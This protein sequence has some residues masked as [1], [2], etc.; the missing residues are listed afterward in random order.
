M[1]ADA[2][3]W[4]CT[5]AGL[6]FIVRIVSRAKAPRHVK[7][8]GYTTIDRR[9]ARSTRCQRLLMAEHIGREASRRIRDQGQGQHTK[10]RMTRRNGLGHR[11]HTHH[12]RPQSAQHPNLRGRFELRAHHPGIHPFVQH[13]AFGGC[14]GS[15][16]LSQVGVIG[17]AHVH[18]T[19]AALQA[20]QG[21][22]LHQVQMVAQG[23]EGPG[24]PVG[25]QTAGR[26]RDHDGPTAHGGHRLD[27]FSHGGGVAGLI[28]ML[29][30]HQHHHI[31]GRLWAWR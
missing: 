28:G 31:K 22:S 10:T 12:I 11:A 13:G 27:G 17:Q 5:G 3:A 15:G 20:L 30:A 4:A 7:F 8:I 19:V 29:T 16:R 24:R 9:M 21:R 14:S 23:H 1:A 6:V 26:I 25:M 18:K 2:G